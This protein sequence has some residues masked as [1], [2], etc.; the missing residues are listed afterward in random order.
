MKNNPLSS[1]LE[2]YLEAIAVIVEQ[3]GHAHTKDIAEKLKVKMP[4]VTNALQA[5]AERDLIEYKSHSPVQLTAKGAESASAIIHRHMGLKRFFVRILKL[6]ESEADDAACR[7]EHIVNEKV[8]SRLVKLAIAI[9]ERE[10]TAGLREYID[11]VL[12]ET[13]GDENAMLIP[14]SQLPYGKKAVV[15]RISEKMRGIKKFADLGIIAGSL[16]QLDSKA[17]FGDLLVIRVL[18]STLSLRRSEAAHI[19][20]RQI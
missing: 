11:R 13:N 4:S 20:V 8:V 5:L 1:S 14:L 9:S 15:V 19:W 7:V 10:D 6:S 12:P 3:K 2:D 18:G 16:L 17:P